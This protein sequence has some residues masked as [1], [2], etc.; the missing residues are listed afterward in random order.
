[1]FTQVLTPLDYPPAEQSVYLTVKFYSV[2]NP[3][4]TT[5]R[6]QNGGNGGWFNIGRYVTT[7]N[8][9]TKTDLKMEFISHSY[10]NDTNASQDSIVILRFK[11]G[12][13]A[14]QTFKG[15]AQAYRIGLET[16]SP[17]VIQNSS[18]P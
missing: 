4:T 11:T 18:R 2:Y 5:L 1:M 3:N 7:N 16:H 10:Y 17:D 12:S 8:G 9:D 13:H 15:N 6:L 14:T